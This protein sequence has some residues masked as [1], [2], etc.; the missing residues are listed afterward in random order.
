LGILASA[1]ESYASEA[2]QLPLVSGDSLGKEFDE[3]ARNIESK[4]KLASIP[5]Y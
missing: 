4:L 5:I 1:C 2:R 3:T